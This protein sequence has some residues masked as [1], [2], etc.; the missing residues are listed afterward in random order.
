MMSMN[1][2]EIDQARWRY[3]GHP[4]K[5]IAARILG[6]LRDLANRV[7]DGWAYW[8]KPCRASRQLQE[9]IQG[10]DE[11]ATLGALRKSLVPIRSF[12]TRQAANLQGMTLDLDVNLPRPV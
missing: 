4:V 8:P 3:Q 9:L 7:S 5:S 10:P 6:S 1:E 11:Q 12:L 2:S